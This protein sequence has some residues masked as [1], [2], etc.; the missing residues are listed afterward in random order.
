M[1]LT[2]AVILSV[3]EGLTE[4]L[5]I[6]STGHMILA[7]II[8]KIQET[9]FVKSFE[10]IIQSGAI[11]AVV[12]LYLTIILKN[13]ELLKKT[14][15]AFIPTGI[16]GLLLY[17]IIKNVLLGNALITILS[18][19]IGGLALILVELY[20][21]NKEYTK[22][23]NS[24]TY[25]NALLIGLFQ[26]ISIIPGVSRAAATIFGG[27]FM[28]LDRKS[29]VEF[30][31]ILAIPTMLAATGYDLLKSLHSFSASQID[32]VAVGFIGAFITALLV[33]KILLYYVKRYTFIPFGIYRIIVAVV[34]FMVFIK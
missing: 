13:T 19:F 3:I 9:N 11:L 21:K 14:I 23:I 15:V 8:L 7:S 22:D 32:I 4:F 17:K 24:L 31:F 12:V 34:F 20:F 26:S 33:V 10:I 27:M 2:Q 1:N 28:G 29:A 30:S 16:I 25:K 6:S 18:L 5:P